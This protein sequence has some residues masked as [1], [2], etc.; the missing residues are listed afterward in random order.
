MRCSTPWLIAVAFG[1]GSA[2]YAREVGACSCTSANA[3]L[4]PPLGA[5]H[6]LAL[7]LVYYSNYSELALTD[8]AGT[9]FDLV[10][11]RDAAG[12]GLCSVSY[13]F[14]VPEPP[15]TAGVEYVLAPT[16]GGDP[17]EWVL[18]HT[19]R[20]RASDDGVGTTTVQLSL[21]AMLEAH[22]P[23][24]SS[25]SGCGDTKLNGRILSRAASAHFEVNPPVDLFV[26]VTVDDPVAGPLVNTTQTSVVQDGVAHAAASLPV[27]DEAS[28]CL[29]VQ[30]FD[31]SGIDVYRELLC[32]ELDAPVSRVVDVTATVLD[33]SSVAGLGQREGERV[34]TTGCGC[35]VPGP[36]RTT[37]TGLRA[38]A[39]AGLLGVGFVAMRRRGT[40]RLG[41]PGL[42][43][44]EHRVVTCDRSFTRSPRAA[45]LRIEGAPDGAGDRSR[46]PRCSPTARRRIRSS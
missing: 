22:E 7:P 30:V 10:V 12:F 42:R 18:E 20:F 16:L 17:P 36:S 28:T 19:V 6:P 9:A 25:G 24:Q 39:I 29:D 37:S 3:V 31:V 13:H 45:R 32:P 43:R 27:P 26:S 15:L 14:V 41:C 23:Y 33:S 21:D 38:A 40:R 11:A 44:F 5:S 8:A 4:S 2:L 35:R 1:V 34:Y 46:R